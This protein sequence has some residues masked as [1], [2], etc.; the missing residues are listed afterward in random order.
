MHE[1]GICR[2]PP[3]R[4]FSIPQRK[5]GGHW[6]DFEVVRR[7]L[8]PYL[9]VIHPGPETHHLCAAAGSLPSDSQPCCISS[10]DAVDS[11]NH[12]AHSNGGSTRESHRSSTATMMARGSQ[13]QSHST[14]EGAV[15]DRL[16]RNGGGGSGNGLKVQHSMPTQQELVAAGRMDL[17]NAT[18]LWGGFTAVAD[19]MGV[20]PN[21]RYNP[22]ASCLRSPAEHLH[23]HV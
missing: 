1:F 16:L 11:N 12:D 4:Q 9:H 8:Q 22:L 17:L 15:Q 10:V 3:Q 5:T 23:H 19:L 18:R 14:G 7:E 13:P 2:L 21:N 20:R 6:D